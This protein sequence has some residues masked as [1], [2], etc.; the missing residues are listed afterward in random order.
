MDGTLLP[1]G[2]SAGAA[3]GPD[4]ARLVC[5]ADVAAGVPAEGMSAEGMSAGG[6]P[7]EGI[8]AE[9]IPA[10]VA[11]VLAGLPADVLVLP[12]P[13]REAL[14]SLAAA[15]ATLRRA[16]VASAGT[17]V[18]AAE[19]PGDGGRLAR[20]V[21]PWGVRLVPDGTT[22]TLRASGPCAPGR[23]EAAPA[24]HR[25]LVS[26][27]SASGKSAF[28][29]NLLAAEP[30]VTYL[31]TGRQTGPDDEEWARRVA[32]H[33]A[34]RPSWWASVESRDAAA[35]LGARR[36][37]AGAGHTALLWDSVGSWLTGV[38]DEVGAWDDAPCWSA[39]VEAEVEA[40]VRAFGSARG[41][42]VAVTEEVGWGVVPATASGRLFADLLGR[43]NQELAEVSDAVTLVVAG[44]TLDLR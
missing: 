4:G 41:R 22:W 8:P 25:H 16:G 43:V 32:A 31:A 26:G 27:P 9:G 19:P 17:D 44:R 37:P 1:V 35:V 33:V 38:L 5:V 13:T 29:E 12:T 18:V 28:A 2:R 36:D 23:A 39:R 11:E 42:V 7:A 21:A 15:L 3:V 14:P 10:D 34:R 40:V 6:I 30:C 20:L 24:D